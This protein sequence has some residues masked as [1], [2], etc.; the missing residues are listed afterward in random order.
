[1]HNGNSL[2]AVLALEAERIEIEREATPAWLL[3]TLFD[4]TLGRALLEGCYER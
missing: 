4:G 2:F 1:M 3:F